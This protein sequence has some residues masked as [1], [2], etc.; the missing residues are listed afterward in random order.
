MK[1]GLEF[2]TEGVSNIF[3]EDTT[4][5]KEATEEKLFPMFDLAMTV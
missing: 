1:M 5:R 2:L 3:E 4:N